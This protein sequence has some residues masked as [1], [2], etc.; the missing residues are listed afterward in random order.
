MFD[1]LRTNGY[2]YLGFTLSKLGCQSE[3]EALNQEVDGPERATVQK[4][5][6]D[7]PWAS[8]SKGPAEKVDLRPR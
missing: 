4:G 5:G 6:D 8:A 3:R 2:L 7:E 1:P